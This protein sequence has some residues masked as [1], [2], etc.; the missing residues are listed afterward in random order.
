[1]ERIKSPHSRRPAQRR[2]VIFVIVPNILMSLQ[3]PVR[4]KSKHP[5]EALTMR[6][7]H[8]TDT[9]NRLT[10]VSNH[11]CCARSTAVAIILYFY[12]LFLVFPSVHF[13]HQKPHNFSHIT[14]ALIMIINWLNYFGICT[15][16]GP[17]GM[18]VAFRR[19]WAG[20]LVTDTGHHN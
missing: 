18:V 1:M 2:C 19:K 17:G 16:C 5:R 14:Y 10:T 15:L 4:T 9:T 12:L 11:Y 7:A 13:P 8:R 20:W 6:V 3:N